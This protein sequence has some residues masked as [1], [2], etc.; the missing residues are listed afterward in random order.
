MSNR[1]LV[2]LVIAAV[3][4]FL[5][6][7]D[8]ALK[9]EAA[10]LTQEINKE[11][12]ELEKEKKIV[13]QEKQTDAELRKVV[14]DQQSILSGEK[15]LLLTQIQSTVSELN[16][17]VQKLA[18]FKKN[19]DDLSPAQDDSANVFS[20]RL[21][22]SNQN[23]K[24]LEQKLNAATKSEKTTDQEKKKFIA[25]QKAQNTLLLDEISQKISL[26]QIAITQAQARF[27][28]WQ[29]NKKD[30]FDY[31]AQLIELQSQVNS[32]KTGL[33][34]LQQQKKELQA[35]LKYQVDSANFEASKRNSD[36]KNLQLNLQTQ[37][38]NVKKEQ[39]DLQ[40][41]LNGVHQSQ[42]ARKDQIKQL[43][44][45]YSLE[46]QKQKALEIQLEQQQAELKKIEP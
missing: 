20:Q 34:L 13:D 39:K 30:Q 11:K 17:Q 12:T 1:N 7:K 41:S 5:G 18:G 27:T 33:N 2:I 22:E 26:Q 25:D 19:L 28:D 42:E 14:N 43:Q 31:K 38:D 8:L 16:L 4:A 24:D 15:N 36:V 29:K 45:S 40:N 35:G 46:L 32:Q 10:L 21:Q 6:Y 44:Q 3:A 23:L 9:N 37:I